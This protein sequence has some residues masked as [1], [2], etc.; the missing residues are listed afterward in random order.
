MLC[1]GTSETNT[2]FGEFAS[3]MTLSNRGP[4]KKQEYHQIGETERRQKS[5]KQ[6]TGKRNIAGPREEGGRG[7][8]LDIQ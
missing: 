2:H 1:V 6:P 8:G 3:P 5:R 7:K 4:E